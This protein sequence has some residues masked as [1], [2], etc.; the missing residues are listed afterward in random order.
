[1]TGAPTVVVV[2]GGEDP[3]PRRAAGLV[4]PTA[5]VVAADSGLD[6][7]RAAG[8]AVHHVVGDLDS[9]DPR[10]LAGA[11]RAGVHVHRHPADKDATDGELALDLAVAL[12]AE[13]APDLAGPDGGP[14]GGP[15]G[16]VDLAM[17]DG[18]VDLGGGP[19]G[20]VELLV[21]GGGGGRLD[22][23]LA[24]LASLA[25]PGL[26]HLDVTAHLGPATVTVV[27]PGRPRLVAGQPGEQVSLIPL[28]GR[29]RGVTTRG[30]RWALT[31]ADLVPG[32]TRAVSNELTGASGS[33]AVD[34]GTV[35]VVQPGTHAAD[36]QP[37]ATPYDPTPLDPNS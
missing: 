5:V 16:V 9:V 28:H 11:E 18:A 24:D 17:S 1:M 13:L 36:I 12:A 31:G 10:S 4:S 32:T 20:A 6:A 30:L 34:E 37:R 22:H 26:A 29:A 15:Y 21:L 2:L 8:I 3:L 7:A 14:D 35:L 19:D 33:V 25:A 27:R 23:L